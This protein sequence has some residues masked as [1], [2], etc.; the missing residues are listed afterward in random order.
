MAIRSILLSAF[1][2]TLLLTLGCEAG[3]RPRPTS[4]RHV[5]LQEFLFAHSGNK[6]AFDQEYLGQWIEITG[7]VISVKQSGG[8]GSTYELRIGKDGNETFELA[9]IELERSESSRAASLKEKSTVS[10]TGKVSGRDHLE[11]GK[12]Q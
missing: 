5:E 7:K 4:A 9:V 11:S 8:S 3:S 2:V 10:V 6:A 12:I 1:A